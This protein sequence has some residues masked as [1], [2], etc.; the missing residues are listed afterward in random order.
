MSFSKFLLEKYA[1]TSFKHYIYLHSNP[2]NFRR[3]YI[4]SNHIILTQ[5]AHLMRAE[6][7]HVILFEIK[8][9]FN[10]CKSLYFRHIQGYAYK[11][12][13]KHTLF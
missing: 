4:A 7:K 3:F 13:Q 5:S 6:V 10:V 11:T 2:K 8:R 12:T 9:L 1:F